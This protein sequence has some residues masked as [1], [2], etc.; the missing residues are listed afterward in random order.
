MLTFRLRSIR[1][2]EASVRYRLIRDESKEKFIGGG[3]DWAGHIAATVSAKVWS[4]CRLAVEHFN[5]VILTTWIIWRQIFTI[6][7]S[8]KRDGLY[9]SPKLTTRRFKST[10]SLCGF[11]YCLVFG[12]KSLRPILLI[13][14][15][16]YPFNIFTW[17]E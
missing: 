17:I 15:A 10:A 9:L 13:F 8:C 5:I 6:N 2:D 1:G 4:I 14:F 12:F 16:I 3:A 11:R 7:E